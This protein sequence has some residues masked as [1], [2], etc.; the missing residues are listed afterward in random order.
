MPWCRGPI[1]LS[2]LILCGCAVYANP[3][4]LNR[5]GCYLNKQYIYN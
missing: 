5:L 1:Y 2:V 4:L 3:Y